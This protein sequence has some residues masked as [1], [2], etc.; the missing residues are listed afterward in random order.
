MSGDDRG[1][2]LASAHPWLAEPLGE[3]L[4]A[5]SPVARHYHYEVDGTDRLNLSVVRH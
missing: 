5:R 4:D 1:T 2:S 3:W